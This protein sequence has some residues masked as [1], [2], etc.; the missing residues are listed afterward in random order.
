MGAP[1]RTRRTAFWSGAASRPRRIPDSTFVEGASSASSSSSRNSGCSEQIDYVGYAGAPRCAP[2]AECR[3]APAPQQRN[4]R[5]VT[6][7]RFM[8]LLVI[9]SR[10]IGVAAC[11][12]D[13]LVSLLV[14]AEE[15]TTAAVTAS[16]AWPAL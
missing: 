2:A 13:K 7:S 14:I 8:S 12:R 9:G 5:S 4:F 16:P 15:S 3:F 10:Q 1:F 6:A 11:Y